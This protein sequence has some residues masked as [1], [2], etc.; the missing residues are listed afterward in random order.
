MKN[1]FLTVCVLVILASFKPALTYFGNSDFG[2]EVA[3]GNVTGVTSEVV[4]G[5]NP[6]ITTGSAP[7]D[8]WL[9]GGTYTGQPLSTVPETIEVFSSSSLDDVGST[10]ADTVRI[11]GLKTNL[12]TEYESEKI[13][14]NGIS[15]VKSTNTWWRVNRMEVVSAG[16]TGANQGTITARHSI[17]TSNVFIGLASTLNKSAVAAYTVPAQS[18]ALLKRI[19]IAMVRTNGSPGSS[20]ITLRYRPLGGVYLSKSFELQDGGGISYNNFTGELFQPGTDIK[21]TVEEVSDN[22]VV[23]E[24][25][26]EILII[27]Q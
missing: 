5:R 2:T 6:A 19:R 11:W 26:M 15:A 17:T 4:F 14:L 7:E 3:L 24:A 1:V 13:A 9:N 21:F 27:K 10:G 8:I 12:S 22:T 18:T 20:N 25:A 16:S 23:A